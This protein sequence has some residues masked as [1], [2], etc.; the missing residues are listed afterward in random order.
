MFGNVIMRPG[1]HLFHKPVGPTSFSVVRGCMEHVAKLPSGRALR[2][3]HG[4]TLDPF[5][6]GL[7]LILVEPATRLFEHLHAIPK[8]YD[9]V[10]RWGIET[11]NG[12]P[13]GKAI[14]KGDPTALTA[15]SLDQALAA[16]V[17]W[18]EQ[19][20]PL[21]SN[22]RV[23]GER[24]YARVHRGED[25]V[26]PPSRVYLHSAQWLGHELPARSHLRLTARG[27]YYVR[28][29]ARDLGRALGCG[30]HLEQ[31]RRL[32]I[33]PWNDPGAGKTACVR[34][35]DLLPWAPTRELG[36][37]ELG[38]LRQ[39]KAIARGTIAP[40]TWALPKGFPDPQS[41]VCGFRQGRLVF[42]LKEDGAQLS[43]LAS[44]PGL[45]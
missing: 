9:A 30:A 31:L 12:D 19:V 38:D 40:G 13:L 43:P 3:C 10:V 45:P 5:A 4:G 18:R 36:D 8:V 2:M 6:S 33:G 23:G 39:G 37:Q 16:M 44:L 15:P 34:G 35:V 29:L 41:P 1:I 42:L 26:L 7:L 11:D 17:G 14:F 25:V 22:R 32:A 24:A 27:G 20:P 28:S 21:T